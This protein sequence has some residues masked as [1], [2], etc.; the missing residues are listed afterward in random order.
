M[1]VCIQV[2]KDLRHDVE[3]IRIRNRK[4]V[5]MIAGTH[6]LVCTKHRPP[7]YPKYPQR[8]HDIIL[9]PFTQANS[10]AVATRPS[11]LP[12]ATCPFGYLASAPTH[13]KY[14]Q[15]N[16][17]VILTPFFPQ[18]VT[19]IITIGLLCLLHA[20]CLLCGYFIR[21]SHIVDLQILAI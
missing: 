21:L 10:V 20:T 12:H 15:R 11:Y 3:Q 13:P 2:V 1:S 14:L 8:V 4:K 18:V 5:D 9:T 17:D 19:F 7:P 6:F 16:S